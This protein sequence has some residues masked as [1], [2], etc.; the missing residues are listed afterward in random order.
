MKPEELPHFLILLPLFYRYKISGD[1]ILALKNTG[2]QHKVALE[3]KLCA[4]IQFSIFNSSPTVA[5]ISN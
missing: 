1:K 5:C 2:F 3:V 4:A